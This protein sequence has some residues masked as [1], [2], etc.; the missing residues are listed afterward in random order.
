MDEIQEILSSLKCSICQNYLSVPPIH[1]IFEE[2]F[3][4][5]RCLFITI[6]LKSRADLYERLA[7]FYKFPCIY[8]GCGQEI[9]WTD[10]PHHEA[11]CPKRI[12]MC[13][14]KCNQKLN[15]QE[16]KEHFN[17]QHIDSRFHRN[18]LIINPWKTKG[19]QLM[20]NPGTYYHFTN[21]SDSQSMANP[22]TYYY[23]G[24]QSMANPGTYYPFTNSSGSQSG[25][26]SDF[27]YWTPQTGTVFAANFSYSVSNG[28]M[29]NAENDHKYEGAFAFSVFSLLLDD[30]S[31][32]MITFA[33]KS[34]SVDK[35]DQI[36][37]PLTDK[38]Q[39]NKCLFKTCENSLH[40]SHYNSIHKNI[41]N[42]MKF[43]IKT[44]VLHKLFESDE[45]EYTITINHKTTEEQMN[46]T[47]NSKICK[48]LQEAII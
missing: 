29:G 32:F 7:K 3:R 11:S 15:I 13:P 41:T 39:C 48:V 27:S 17:L 9:P 36:I 21:S 26:N 45:V 5:G 47:I 24:S 22:G 34:V 44:E 8:E 42:H 20:A 30:S 40:K 1:Y 35:S 33:S 38:N 4:C 31:S 28:T 16:M 23:S 12:V 37:K 19:S 18:T 14:F 10:V 46:E 6:N 2:Q 43:Q 25:A